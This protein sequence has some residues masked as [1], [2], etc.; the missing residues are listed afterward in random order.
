MKSKLFSVNMKD[1]V[2]GLFI[3]VAT[4]IGTGLT[5]VLNTGA[6]PDKSSLKSVGIAG[7]AAGMAYVVKN[8]FTNSN[9]EL[10]KKE[11]TNTTNPANQG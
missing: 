4:A 2:R 8:F 10:L 5:Q 9:D 3:A 1:A 11:S 6:L 7:A